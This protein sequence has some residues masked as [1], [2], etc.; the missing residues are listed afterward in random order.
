MLPRLAVLAALLLLPLSGCRNERVRPVEDLTGQRDVS[1]F[2]L[3]SIRGTRDGDRLNVQ[4]VFSGN[5]GEALRL[6]LQFTVGVPTTLKSGTW[7]GPGSG[8]AVRERSVT[9]L[10]GQ[11]GPPSIGGRFDLLTGGGAARFRVTIPLQE[12]KEKL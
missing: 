4:A 9:F 1:R 5:S 3:S 6:N 12:L 2:V 8:G 10:G 11:S 7:T